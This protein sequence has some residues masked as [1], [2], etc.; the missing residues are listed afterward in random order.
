MRFPRGIMAA[1]LLALPIVLF[2]LAAGP[3]RAQDSGGDPD[4]GA[5]LYAENCVVCH[6]PN[7][8]GRAGAE[9]NDVFATIAPDVFLEQVISRGRDGTFMP[10]WNEDYGGPLT[11]AEVDDIVAYIES[12]GTTV[13]PPLPAPNPPTQVIPPV[14]EVDGD[15]NAGF[16][17]YSENCQA[18]HGPSGEGR[19]GAQLQEAFAAIEPGAF[20]ITTISR[21]IEGS[22]MPPF[23][24]DNGGPLSDQQ[25]DDVAAYVLSFQHPAG[26]APAGEVVGR[27]SGWPLAFALLAVLI[28]LVALGLVLGGRPPSDEG[29]SSGEAG[30]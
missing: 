18:C 22:L 13:E 8:E 9:L 24:Q 27:A 3:A 26:P 4:N 5:T 21:G 19:I 2:G 12:W 1:G 28:L 14:P 20:A 6:G 7:G 11:P 10:A 17:V 16:V 15:P 25:I 23:A 30:A 29:G